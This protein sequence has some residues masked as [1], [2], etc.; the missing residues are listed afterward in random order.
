MAPHLSPSPVVPAHER[1][2]DGLAT[3][4]SVVAH[5]LAIFVLLRQAAPREFRDFSEVL[6]ALYLYAPDRQPAAPRELRIPVP[7]P[8]G[9]P[10]GADIP[11]ASSLPGAAVVPRK[12]RPAAG[13]LPPGRTTVRLDSVFSVLAVDSEV[14]RY[15]SAAPA[16]PKALLEGGVEG[17]VEAEFV[18][19]TT[20]R[21]DLTTIRILR[22]SHEEFSASVQAALAGASFRPA[23]RNLRKVRQLVSQ[24][25]AFRIYRGPDSVSM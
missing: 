6:P 1:A 4:V 25:F 21:V 2:L 16:Y 17:S 9:D 20:G 7:A 8:A 23:W 15:P 10:A 12:P 19:D 18:V 14:V 24:R 5:G 22:S 11:V 13:L 3:M